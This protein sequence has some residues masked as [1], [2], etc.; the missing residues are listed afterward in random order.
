MAYKCYVYTLDA[1]STRPTGFFARSPV[2]YVKDKEWME[3]LEVTSTFIFER[4]S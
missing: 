4:C 2:Q 1:L 3:I